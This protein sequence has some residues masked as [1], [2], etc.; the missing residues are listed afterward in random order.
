MLR[1]RLLRGC[2]LLLI[3]SLLRQVLLLRLRGGLTLLFDSLMLVPGL[4]P[5]DLA[6]LVELR[7]ML[8]ALRGRLRRRG[9]G[10]Q[11]EARDCKPTEHP[12]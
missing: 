9:N 6:H 3:L 12:Y 10:E 2:S 7:L 5:I 11:A 4:L 1:F 8:C